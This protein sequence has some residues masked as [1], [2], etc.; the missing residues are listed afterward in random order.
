MFFIKLLGATSIFLRSFDRTVYF[1]KTTVRMCEILRTIVVV[2]VLLF[3]LH[4]K[5]L[6]LC[7]GGQLT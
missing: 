6:W 2:D 3:Y 7:R 4:G 1:N 5:Q